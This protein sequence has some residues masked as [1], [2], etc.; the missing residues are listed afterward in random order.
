MLQGDRY[1]EFSCFF[2]GSGDRGIWDF[3]LI[4][5]GKREGLKRLEKFVIIESSREK[6]IS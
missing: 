3:F 2:G 5:S 6:E 1:F 4:D